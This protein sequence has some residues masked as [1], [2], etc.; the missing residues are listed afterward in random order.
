MKAKE[1]YQFLHL[2]I[3]IQWW[4][5]YIL[6]LGKLGLLAAHD[7]RLDLKLHMNQ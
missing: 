1:N 3:N 5:G 4:V 6:G 2:K 7:K